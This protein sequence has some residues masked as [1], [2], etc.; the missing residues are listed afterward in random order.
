MLGKVVLL[1]G[2]AKHEGSSSAVLGSYLLERLAEQ[3]LTTRTFRVHMV[4]R[5]PANRL[6]LVNEVNDCELFVVAYPLYVDTLPALVIETFEMLAEA[7]RG[8]YA[9]MPRM[10][11]IANCGFPEAQHNDN[12]LKIC[13]RFAKEAG[14][15]WVGG[16]AMGMGGV[17]GGERLESK[18]GLLRNVQ[19]GLDEAA[20]ALAAGQVIPASAA[21]KLSR[22][23]MQ[24][25]LYRQVAS[26]G[27]R[28][29]A[30]EN[31]VRGQLR[32]KPYVE[33]G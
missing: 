28:K 1:V 29:W 4:L 22:P 8:G 18:G 30:S 11:V 3:G 5:T 15:V 23:V 14:F 19:A 2:S 6:E 26:F 16:L 7:R 10:A 24:S 17:V 9:T 20:V 33:G 27:W 21:A 12:S 32:R 13:Q 31:R 25:W